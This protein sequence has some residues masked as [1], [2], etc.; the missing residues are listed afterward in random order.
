MPY[1]SRRFAC[2][3]DSGSYNQPHAVFTALTF[4]LSARLMAPWRL[5]L[6][7]LAAWPVDT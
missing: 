7:S 4:L 6:S 2:L 3:T 1:L 5:T